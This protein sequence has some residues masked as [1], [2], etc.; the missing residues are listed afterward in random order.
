MS[1]QLLSTFPPLGG[2]LSLFDSWECVFFFFFVILVR[3]V[4]IPP[5]V[6]KSLF[7]E[8]IPFRLDTEAR[9]VLLTASLL[10]AFAV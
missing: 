3:I 7:P 6:C 8:V 10:F 2:F 1:K 9:Y 5:N 4:G